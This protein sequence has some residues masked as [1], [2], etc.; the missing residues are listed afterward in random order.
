MEAA[1][2]RSAVAAPAAAAWRKA[3]DAHPVWRQRNAAAVP[4]FNVH[5]SSL[6]IAALADLDLAAIA[7]EV[8][9]GPAGEACRSRLVGDLACD[10]DASWIRRQ[11]APARYP[12]GHAPHSWHQDGALGFDFSAAAMAAGTKPLRMLTC[13]IALT[14]CGVDAPGLE[15]MAGD[16]QALLPPAELVDADVRARHGSAGFW[17]PSLEPGDALLFGGGVLHRTHVTPAMRHDR[18]SVELRFFAASDL[19]ERLRDHRFLVVH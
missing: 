2:V 14:P 7:G 6:R 3:I 19:P 10:A 4:D 16:L 17:R 9:R 5:S 15:L 11:Y 8:L 18:T 1:F 12:P 13:W